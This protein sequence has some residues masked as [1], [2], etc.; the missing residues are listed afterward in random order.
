MSFCKPKRER[1]SVCHSKQVLQTCGAVESLLNLHTRHQIRVKLVHVVLCQCA[2]LL[3]GFS[4]IYMIQSVTRLGNFQRNTNTASDY[5]RNNIIDKEICFQHLKVSAQ[6]A[7]LFC[8]IFVIQGLILHFL[9]TCPGIY[10]HVVIYLSFLILILH[11]VWLC[12]MNI[13][14]FSLYC[15]AYDMDLTMVDIRF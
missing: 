9:W 5:G 12:M 11:A 2:T 14:F 8:S 10:I 13:F 4:N 3:L 6:S 15:F 1:S 7:S